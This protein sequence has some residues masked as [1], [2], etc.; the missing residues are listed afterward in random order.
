MIEDKIA[1][2][3]FFLEKM[4]EESKKEESNY[5]TIF[6]Y[7]SAFLSA[8][9]S[10]Y[11]YALHNANRVFKLGLLDEER[12]DWQKFQFEAKKQKNSS[13]LKYLD[14]WHSRQHNDNNMAIGKAFSTCRRINTHKRP[15]YKIGVDID[16]D[17][18]KQDESPEPPAIISIPIKINPIVFLKVEGFEQMPVQEACS[19]YLS[20][21]EKF[22]SDHYKIIDKI[23]H[24]EL[25]I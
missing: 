9:Y 17:V 19:A 13:A 21:I 7:Y 12:W 16:V 15:T 23:E 20:T 10:V 18:G 1:E 2:S 6:C 5:F 8:S 25:H 22:S 3:K 14:W 11:D 4:N 24:E